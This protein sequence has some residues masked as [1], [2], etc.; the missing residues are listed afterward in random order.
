LWGQAGPVRFLLRP[1]KAPGRRA[2]RIYAIRIIFAA[3]WLTDYSR[4]IEFEFCVQ[5]FVNEAKPDRRCGQ[6]WK[7][8]DS[9][10]VVIGQLIIPQQDIDTTEAAETARALRRW[11]SIRGGPPIRFARWKFE[12]RQE[13]RV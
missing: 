4:A 13:G 2:N 7:E 10:P 9:A 8:N 1:V 11:P 6:E 5:R 12:S 3:R